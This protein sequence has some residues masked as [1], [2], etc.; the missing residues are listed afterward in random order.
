MK[1]KAKE[2][3]SPYNII[4]EFENKKALL[5]YAIERKMF[6]NGSI[7]ENEENF[8]PSIKKSINELLDFCNLEQIKH[9]F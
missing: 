6:H 5:N 8:K 1:I 9:I 2:K 3:H 7:T 4:Y